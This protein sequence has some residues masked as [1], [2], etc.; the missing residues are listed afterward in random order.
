LFSGDWDGLAGKFGAGPFIVGS[1]VA[2]GFA[3]LIGGPLGVA[4]GVFFSNWH[5]NAWRLR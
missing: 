3:I 4:I 5:P 1:L 2:T